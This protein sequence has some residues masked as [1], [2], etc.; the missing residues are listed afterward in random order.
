MPLVVQLTDDEKFLFKQD[1]KLEEVGKLPREWQPFLLLS[2]SLLI[3]LFVYHA[4]QISLS[5][6]ND[7]SLPG[8]GPERNG[9][10]NLADGN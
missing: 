4:H 9:R 10:P 8:P 1:L 5:R 7:P 3:L 2:L 6:E